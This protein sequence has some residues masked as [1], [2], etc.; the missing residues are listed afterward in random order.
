MT[1]R[2]LL[3]LLPFGLFAILLPMGSNAQSCGPGTYQTT[4]GNS[5]V[6]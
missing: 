5:S 3:Y 2:L 6:Q 1:A 4:I